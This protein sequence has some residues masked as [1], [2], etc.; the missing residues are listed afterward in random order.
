MIQSAPCQCIRKWHQMHGPGGLLTCRGHTNNSRWTVSKCL[1][2]VG[3]HYRGRWVFFRCDVLPF[4]AI[5]AAY[6]F[7]R[8]SRSLHFLICKLLW[9][10]GRCFCD[11]Y[12]TISPN[13]SAAILSKA[14]SAMFTL[15]GWD[16]AKVGIKALDFVAS[17]NALGVISTAGPPQ[18]RV[19]HLV[20]YGRAH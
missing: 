15:L 16:H 18:Q 5:A 14:M 7:N 8:V 13:V 17:F 12:P 9:G 11:D 10:P 1:S 2:V 3:Y 19:L 4:G 6:S 20:Q